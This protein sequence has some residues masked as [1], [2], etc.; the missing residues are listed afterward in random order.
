MLTFDL[1]KKDSFKNHNDAEKFSPI[2][3][4]FFDF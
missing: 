1:Y 2:K 3:Y 4:S